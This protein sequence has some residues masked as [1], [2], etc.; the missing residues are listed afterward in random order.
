MKEQEL[1][2]RSEPE[3]PVGPRGVD[4]S[5]LLALAAAV[6]M[7]MDEIVRVAKAKADPPRKLVETAGCFVRDL[8]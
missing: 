1:A 6:G 7:D 4:L 5:D 2:L 3:R 8:D